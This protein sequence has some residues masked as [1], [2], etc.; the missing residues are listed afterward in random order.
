MAQ[1]GVNATVNRWSE[2]RVLGMVDPHDSLSHPSGVSDVQ[3]ES[4][5]CL[6]PD[7]F[8]NFVVCYKFYFWSATV[9]FHTGHILPLRSPVIPRLQ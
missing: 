8:S 6:D 9:G 3:A 7:Q 5:V 2:P 1:V 4:A